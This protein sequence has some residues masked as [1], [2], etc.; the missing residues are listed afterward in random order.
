MNQLRAPVRQRQRQRQRGIVIVEFALS[1]SLLLMLL[2]GI[3]EISRLMFY[4]NTATE[5]TRLGARI[6]SVCALDHA[7]IKDRMTVLFPVI[8][9]ADIRIDYLPDGC[10]AS[11]CEQLT[12]SITKL[13]LLPTS[14]PFLPLALQLPSF[15]TS[16]P[17][18][19]MRSHIDST[20][21]PVC[22]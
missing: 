15:S 4:W 3:M 14:I 21:N 16:L 9:A 20:A 13:D 11:D 1:A 6:A 17:R 5:A 12:V 2:L 18:E 8:A 7:E 22:G 19:S 10:S